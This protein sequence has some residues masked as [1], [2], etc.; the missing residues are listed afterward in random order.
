MARVRMQHTVL[1]PR[2]NHL[3]FQ[4][5]TKPVAKSSN[6]LTIISRKWHVCVHPN[7]F[8]LK[9][10][11]EKKANILESNQNKKERKKEMS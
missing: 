10:K 1:L 11:Q 8:F 9:K 4:E 2:F 3:S 7:L 6:A 5:A